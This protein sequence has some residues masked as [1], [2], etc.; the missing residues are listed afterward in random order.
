M[1]LAEGRD[2]YRDPVEFFR[3]T[4]LTESLRE[5]LANA[6]LRLTGQGGDRVV[7]LQT[8]FGGGKTHSML[9]LFLLA[10]G[11]LLAELP[12]VERALVEAARR[13]GDQRQRGEGAGRAD[14]AADCPGTGPHR[15]RQ[16]E[17]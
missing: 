8:N 15:P 6:I 1:Y 11:R 14:P 12:G 13:P 9:D 5:L 2:E 17:D 7:Q 16:R 3:R 4:Y 10:S